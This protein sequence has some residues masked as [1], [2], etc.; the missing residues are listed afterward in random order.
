MADSP[1][2]HENTQLNKKSVFGWAMYD[3][4]NSSYTT[5][6]ITFIYSAFFI[7]HIV[8]EELAHM[9]NS[10][11]AVAI[12]ISTIISIFAAPFVGVICDLS[13]NKKGY[14]AACTFGSV[15]ATAC[16]YF[17]G[18]GNIALGLTFLV[19][20]NTAWM[21]SESFNASLADRY[22]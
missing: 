5:V 9:R 22:F 17:V 21:L 18:P 4:A 11:W 13:G 10:L 8:P 14:L 12:T 7:A 15:F 2:H 6:V 3:F 20:S 1:L 19:I 16:L